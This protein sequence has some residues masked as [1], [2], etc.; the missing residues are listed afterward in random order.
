MVV[1]P[2]GEFTHR[3]RI[4]S[5]FEVRVEHRFALATREVTVA[6]FRR[7]RK[8]YGPWEEAAPTEDC[9]ANNLSW[10]DAAAFCN[11]LSREDGIAEEQWCYLPND[12]GEY[13]E[14]M[15][16]KADAV[17]LSGYRLPTEAEWEYACR[18]GTVTTWSLGEAEELLTKYAWY[19]ANS[20]NRS[21]PVGSLRPNDLG[22]FDMHGNAA[23]WCQNRPADFPGANNRQPEERIA[24]P[25][26]RPLR[27][28]DY[29]ERPL[30]V[31][32]SGRVWA[33]PD[34]CNA[35]FGFRP[36]RTLR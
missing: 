21:R 10:Y 11:W 20:P 25:G 18:A 22:L 9:P 6:D 35:Y 17:S 36:A 7:F 15:R 24:G 5:R 30:E 12:K 4:T 31:K 23:E 14:G 27:G 28:G 33:Y 29:S 32:S 16:I 34:T 13:A 26:R 1:V 8:N 19:V 3:G 2:P